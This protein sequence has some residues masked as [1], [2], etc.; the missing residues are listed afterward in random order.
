MYIGLGAS[1]EERRVKPSVSP[2]GPGEITLDRM[3]RG[4]S[5]TAIT[6]ERA[7]TAAFAADTCAWYGVPKSKTSA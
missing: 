1:F 3:P 2:I 4:P 5:S 7:S 6:R